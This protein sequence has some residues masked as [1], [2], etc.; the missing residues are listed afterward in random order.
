M[1]SNAVAAAA[2]FDASIKQPVVFFRTTLLML[3]QFYF[4]S[5]SRTTVLPEEGDCCIFS[6]RTFQEYSGTGTPRQQV[7]Q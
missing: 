6:S 2:L 4:T 3:F 1:N 5:R 7:R